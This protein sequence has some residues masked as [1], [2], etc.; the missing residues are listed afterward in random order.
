MSATIE[1]PTAQRFDYSPRGSAADVFYAQDPEVLLSGPAGTGKSR[2]ILEKLFLMAQEIYPGMR[3]L[4]VR[5]TRV[6]LTETALFTWENFVLPPNHPCHPNSGGA[7]RAHRQSYRF[8]NGSEIVVGGMDRP[9]KIMSSEYDFIYPQEA[10][11]LEEEDWGA[12]TTRLRNGRVPY[13]QIVGDTN[14]SYPRHWLKQ[15]CDRGVTRL[16]D[17]RH[18][19][20][21]VLHD[22]KGWTQKGVEYIAK[23]DNL[24]GAEKLRLRHG[25][26]VQ[27]EGAVYAEWSPAVHVVDPFPIP[28]DWRRYWVVDFGYTNPFV[29]QRWAEDGDGR[30]YLYRE[31]YRTKRLVEDHVRDILEDCGAVGGQ[32]DR[33]TE[34]KPSQILADHDAEDRATFEKHSKMRTVAADKSVLAGIQDVASRLRPAGDGKPRLFVFRGALVDRDPD[35]VA[36]SKPWCTEQEF[37]GYVWADKAVKEEPVK[38]NDHGMDCVRYLCKR[39]AR[40]SGPAFSVGCV[41]K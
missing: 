4:I 32:W 1:T 41:K 12:L 31:T 36:S 30:A 40:G 22:G 14:P 3:A 21:P 24:T 37:D 18:E 8:P 34:P 26:W 27:A 5:K 38:E 9:A 35:L 25:R 10:I 23:L 16:I 19:D 29:C 15:R 7:H 6:S 17:T 33:A 20:N 13:Q 28:A 2:A 39:L 11:E